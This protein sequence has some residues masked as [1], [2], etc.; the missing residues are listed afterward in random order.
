MHTF[1]IKILKICTW[2]HTK[3]IA[4]VTYGE[5]KGGKHRRLLSC[6]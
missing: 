2:I 3:L 5:G 6:L 4:V 1:V